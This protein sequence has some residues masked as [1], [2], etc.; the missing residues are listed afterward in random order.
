MRDN[1]P[2]AQASKPQPFRET[3]DGQRPFGIYPGREMMIVSEMAVRAIMN[4]PGSRACGDADNFLYFFLCARAAKWVVGIY[5][6][7]NL[8]FRADRIGKSGGLK[9]IFV[10]WAVDRNLLY[11]CS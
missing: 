2:D 6:I 5:D 8:R 9:T 1:R 11:R 4:K 10:F 3:I 7:N